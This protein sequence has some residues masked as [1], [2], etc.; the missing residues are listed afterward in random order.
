MTEGMIEILIPRDLAKKIAEGES[1]KPDKIMCVERFLV[2]DNME[3]EYTNW[4]LDKN[5]P[6][7]ETVRI[8]LDRKEQYFSQD[9]KASTCNK[10][11]IRDFGEGLIRRL[12]EYVL[13]N[14]PELCE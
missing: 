3:V 5:A 13:R 11:M 1:K 2:S 14:I 9:G 4:V 6:V 8:L 10:A 7:K 12:P